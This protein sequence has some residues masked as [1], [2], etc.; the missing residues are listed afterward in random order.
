MISWPALR[1]LPSGE[2][3]FGKVQKRSIDP[4]LPPPFIYFL[5]EI[6]WCCALCGK[7][8]TFASA[9]RMNKEMRIAEHHVSFAP[10]RLQSIHLSGTIQAR[11]THYPHRNTLRMH[12]TDQKVCNL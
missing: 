2:N 9:V 8:L 11:L 6:Q 7:C 10:N 3:G 4:P 5:P 1:A 12:A